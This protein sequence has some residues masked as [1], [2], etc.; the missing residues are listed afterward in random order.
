M[1]DGETRKLNLGVG[2]STTMT[3]TC[4]KKQVEYFVIRFIARLMQ[5]CGQHDESTTPTMLQSVCATWQ[6]HISFVYIQRI[7]S[8]SVHVYKRDA[9][10][11]CM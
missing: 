2:N 8:Y 5:M 3:P 9:P 11:L 1:I 6:L 7:H 10:S 4:K